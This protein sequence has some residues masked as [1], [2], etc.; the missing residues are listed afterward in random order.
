MTHGAILL[1]ALAVLLGST[2]QEK[3]K[4][5]KEVMGTAHKG[6]ASLLKKITDGKGTADDNK[7]LLGLYEALASFKPPQ[8]EEKSWKDKTGALVAAAKDLVDK[9]EGAMDSLKKATN[10]KAC[11]DIHRPK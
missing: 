6:N 9:K 2:V 4:S 3:A 5:I 11:H 7:Q 1:G 10:C 8:G